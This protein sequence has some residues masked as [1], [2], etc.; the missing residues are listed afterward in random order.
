M[1]SCIQINKLVGKHCK[2]RKRKRKKEKRKKEKRKRKKKKRRL[3]YNEP[4]HESQGGRIDKNKNV[5]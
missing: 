4:S 3:E 1:K 2:K 5:T